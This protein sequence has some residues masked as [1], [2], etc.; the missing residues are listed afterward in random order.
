ML[1]V[2]VAE[3]LGLELSDVRVLSADSDLCPVDLGAY[4]SRI[5]LMVGNACLQAARSLRGRVCAAVARRWEVPPRRVSLIERCAVDLED[6]ARRIPV[7]EAFQMAEAHE[8]LLAA[9]GNYDTP[10]DRHGSYR[11]GT[12]GASPAYSFTAHVVELEVDP[13]TGVI[14]VDKVWVAH[15]CGKAL[16]PRIVE[17][18]MEGSV[19]MGLA[20]ALMEQHVVD[21]GHGGVHTGPSLLDYRMPTFLDSPDIRSLIVEHPDAQGP[22][23]AKE[24]GEGPLHPIIPAIANAIHDAVGVRIESTPFSPPK[25]LAAIEAA[26]AAGQRTAAQTVPEVA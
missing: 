19:Y 17:G 5:T 22:Y 7:V 13:E 18:Q 9:V 6:P 25:V 11:G 12:I 20:E 1:A 14:T 21:P 24:A 10:R 8:G 15:D 2:I 23:G 16:S 4:S 26:R 3:E